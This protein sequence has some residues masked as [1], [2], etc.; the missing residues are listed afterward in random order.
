MHKGFV[1]LFMAVAGTVLSP[2][3]SMADSSWTGPYVGLSAGW[4]GSD[5]DWAFNP[6]VPNA[7]NQAFSFSDDKVAISPYLGYQHQFGAFV[8]GA[9]VGYKALLDD[10]FA[11]H[12]GY[13]T[14][15]GS[16]AASKIDGI[17]T[18][19]GRLGYAFGNQWLLYGTGGYARATV[20]TDLISKATGAAVAGFHTSEHQDGWYI[21]G[22]AD[23]KLTDHLLLGIEYQH[24]SFD[25]EK[26]CVSCVSG[27]SA[28][29]NHDVS[30]DV[31]VVSARLTFLLGRDAP[32]AAPLK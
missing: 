26:H 15:S 2:A 12:D 10:D 4:A 11:L 7:S 13:G 29:N 20:E 28:F 25:E 19:G 31:D 30:A 27:F 6:P 9:E 24:L 32:A 1:A 17:F 16:F 5:V 18:V 14:G 22:G 8:I 23:Y 21:G 3:A